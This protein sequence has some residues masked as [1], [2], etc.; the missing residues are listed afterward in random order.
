MLK[1]CKKLWKNHRK[2]FNK[3]ALKKIFENGKNA[4]KNGRRRAKNEEK[5]SKIKKKLGKNEVKNCWKMV[6]NWEKFIEDIEK[7]DL[8]KN[9]RKRLVSKLMEKNGQK[10]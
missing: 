10:L 6:K 7:K 8:W 5:K 3:Q 4:G 1:N 2:K 9:R